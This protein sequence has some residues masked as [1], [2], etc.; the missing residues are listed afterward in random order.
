[1]YVGDETEFGVNCLHL[2]C[3]W[4]VDWL[5]Q[6]AGSEMARNIQEH[7]Q[8]VL[9]RV[10]HTCGVREEGNGA[11]HKILFKV[12]DNNNTKNRTQKVETCC[13]KVLMECGTLLF[14]GGLN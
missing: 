8:G 13:V 10:N 3:S 11:Q 14:E 12:H 2:N 5:S 9:W 4:M 6:E 7:N 1:M